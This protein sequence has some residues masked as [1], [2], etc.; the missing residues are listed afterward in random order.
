[1]TG[2]DV[3]TTSNLGGG[4]RGKVC[5]DA[6]RPSRRE[7]GKN[8]GTV[9]AKTSATLRNVDDDRYE[10]ICRRSF[11]DYFGRWIGEAMREGGLA[12]TAEVDAPSGT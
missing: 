11:A 6:Q 9:F 10:L 2:A 12:V 7:D 4:G 1:M 8:A 5:A 3:K